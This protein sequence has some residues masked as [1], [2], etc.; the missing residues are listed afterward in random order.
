MN[1]FLKVLAVT[2]L[3]FGLLFVLFNWQNKLYHPTYVSF[4]VLLFRV[5]VGIE[6][7]F[8]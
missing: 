4:G 7:G 6:W 3:E 8:S 1:K 2:A 5:L